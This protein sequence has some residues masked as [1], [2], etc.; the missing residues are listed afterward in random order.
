M[1]GKMTPARQANDA[2]DVFSSF[3]PAGGTRI[4]SGIVGFVRDG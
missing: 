3:H 2:S 4:L 1:A